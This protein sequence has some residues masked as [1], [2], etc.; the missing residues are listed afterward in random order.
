MYS[1]TET[2]EMKTTERILE[3]ACILAKGFLR[4]RKTDLFST[5]IDTNDVNALENSR[6]L[7][8]SGKHNNAGI[9]HPQK[10]DMKRCE[11]GIGGFDDDNCSFIRL[12]F[13]V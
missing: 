9:Q 8:S 5:S 2:N 4:I 6:S 11:K 1:I 7:K 12:Q 3:V 13:L 10:H